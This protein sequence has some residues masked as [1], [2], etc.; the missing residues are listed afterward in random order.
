MLRLRA[1]TLGLDISIEEIQ[2]DHIPAHLPGKLYVRATSCPVTTRPGQLEAGNQAYVLATIR[3]ATQ[4]CLAGHYDAMVTA[5]VNKAVI[6]QAGYPFSGHTEFIAELCESDQAVMVLDNGKLRVGLV[7]THLPLS[8]VSS[9]ITSERVSSV[10]LTLAEG[11]QRRYGIVKPK[12]IVCG[13]NPHA[14]EQ[15]ELGDEENNEIIPALEQLREKGLQLNGPLPADTAFTPE[16]LE[17]V[18]LVVAM[19]HDQ[20]LPVLKSQGF[21]N[22]VNVTFGLPIIRTSVDHGTALALAGSGRA[23]AESLQC[24]VQEAIRLVKVQQQAAL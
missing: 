2:Q 21:G 16:S 7:T 22:T 19:Y 17:G 5:P 15:G 24:A 4:G 1:S 13:L 14:G 10:I 6:N 11:L 18:D 23:S 12:L 3:S 8:E 9:R 20:G